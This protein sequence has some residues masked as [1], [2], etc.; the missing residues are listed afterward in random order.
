[1][2][3]FGHYWLECKM[4]QLFKRAIWQYIIQVLQFT[5]FNPSF[6]PKDPRETIYTRTQMYSLTLVPF[7]FFIY[8]FFWG[9]SLQHVEIPRPGAE[10]TPQQQSETRAVTA[11]DLNLLCHQGT[12]FQFF[13]FFFFKY[14]TEMNVF[15]CVF[16][17]GWI[18]GLFFL[19]V[20]YFY[21][22]FIVYYIDI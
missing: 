10:P 13:F 3:T 5:F 12:P 15:C 4:V 19:A 7:L 20:I 18:V 11:L 2:S 6:N 1:M 16:P 8:L 17:N 21:D 14:K 22:L 9:P